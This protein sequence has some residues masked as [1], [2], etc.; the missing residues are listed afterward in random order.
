MKTKIGKYEASKYGWAY[1][2]RELL[3]KPYLKSIGDYPGKKILDLGCGKGWI[4]KILAKKAK[5][6]EG[7]AE[8]THIR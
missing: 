7:T 2:E 3:L 4:T 1:Q 8:K 5:K 6:V